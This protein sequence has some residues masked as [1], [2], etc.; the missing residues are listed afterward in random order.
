MSSGNPRSKFK[1]SAKVQFSVFSTKNWPLSNVNSTREN[2]A[3][4]SIENLHY[5]I[6]CHSSYPRLSKAKKKFKATHFSKLSKIE[7]TTLDLG[8]LGGYEILEPPVH[9]GRF[10]NFSNENI[11]RIIPQHCTFGKNF[12]TPFKTFLPRNN[13]W[14]VTWAMIIF[15]WKK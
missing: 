8:S 1:E 4:E 12:Q 11:S 3:D 7:K 6:S 13:A 10:P 5:H 2:Y 15:V 9:T 14:N